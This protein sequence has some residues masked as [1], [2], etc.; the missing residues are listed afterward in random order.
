MQQ[1]EK[2]VIDEKL[3][4]EILDLIPNTDYPINT[5]I[6][7]NNLNSIHLWFGHKS[8]REYHLIDYQLYKQYFSKPT[9]V[10]RRIGTRIF[11]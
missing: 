10:R 3:E 7:C 9:K 5:K 6:Y 11:K 2:Q 4:L 8:P 1:E